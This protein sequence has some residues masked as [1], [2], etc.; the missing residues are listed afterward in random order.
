MRDDVDI[1]E[2]TGLR[3]WSDDGWERTIIRAWSL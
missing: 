2:M 1:V 3:Y